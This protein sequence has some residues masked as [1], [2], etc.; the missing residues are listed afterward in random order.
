MQ[1][2][3]TRHSME[4]GSSKGLAWRNRCHRASASERVER[5]TW[6]WPNVKMSSRM[7]KE[8]ESPAYQLHGAL[9]LY[10]LFLHVR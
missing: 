9:H 4:T 7:K 3:L 10:H 5:G 2:D 6:G 1:Q 8:S